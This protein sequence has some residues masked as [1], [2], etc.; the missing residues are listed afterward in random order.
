MEIIRNC[1]V[2]GVGEAANSV[3]KMII[4]W[5]RGLDT[6]GG[7]GVVCGNGDPFGFD[8][9]SLAILCFVSSSIV[10]QDKKFRLL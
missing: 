5:V 3:T 1:P 4:P 8:F 2:V 9:V 7:G 10:L 6:V